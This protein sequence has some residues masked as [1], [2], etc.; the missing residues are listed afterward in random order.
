MARKRFTTEQIIHELREAEV[1]LPKGRSVGQACKKIG[2]KTLFIDRGAHGRAA[3]SSHSTA[4]SVT[5]C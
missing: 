4:S 5:S 2:V 3:T 1:E